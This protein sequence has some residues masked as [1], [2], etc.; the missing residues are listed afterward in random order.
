[1]NASIGSRF[2]IAPRMEKPSRPQS[3]HCAVNH[4]MT[5][6]LSQNTHHHSGAQ[7][8]QILQCPLL[9]ARL[10]SV[11]TLGRTVENRLDGI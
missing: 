11:A 3:I 9:K 1:M 5:P 7:T 8:P 4:P 6:R 10:L 2:L